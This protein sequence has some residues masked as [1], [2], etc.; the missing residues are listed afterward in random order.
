M[1]PVKLLDAAFLHAETAQT[2]MHVGA[3]FVLEKP[4]RRPRK[5]F[6][7]RFR[8]LVAT[9]L[10]A[11][12]V[13]TR[14]LAALPFDIA[15]PFWAITDDIDLDHHVRHWT[16][17]APG[18][19]RQLETRVARLH[20]PLMDRDRPLWELH[21]IDGLEDGRIALYVKTHHAGLDGHT[22][23]LFL[24]AFVDPGPR[25]SSRARPKPLPA[26]DAASLAALLMAGA[27]HQLAELGRVP[28]RIRELADAAATLRRG[29]DA[30]VPE[31][32]RTILNEV[33]SRR[34]SF[35][36]AEVDLEQVRALAR[37]AQVKVNDV[38]L[39]M[40]AAAV[41]GWLLQRGLLPQ[42]PL[43]AGV[44]VSARAAGD[45]DHSIQVAF[46][47]VNLHTGAGD[48]L[49]RLMAIHRSASAAKDTA[50]SFKALIP[51]DVPSVGL[52][53]LLGGVA[54]LVSHPDVADRVPLPFNVI[55]SNVPGPPTTLYVAGARVGTY[56]P[57]SIVYHGVGLNVTAYSYDGKLF[58][59]VTACTDLMPD[60]QSFA[61][62]MTGE[63]AVLSAA[64]ERPRARSGPRARRKARG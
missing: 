48:P 42:L 63:L 4:S 24:Q 13:F 54:R 6:H 62:L 14:R 27:R 52:P 3:L 21:V 47:S 49:A 1:K 38:L 7:Q 29:R 9:R 53:W 32:P 36:T 40:T 18:S 8:E 35:A 30:S 16:L 64:L 28:R 15:N 11:S 41:R 60:V 39:A 57:V 51:D 34:R 58:I 37:R 59:G 43:F 33:V 50:G 20:E 10:G 45:T 17:P 55:V 46:I 26:P 44:P 22:A 56:L 19:W 12:E 5:P 25:P 23:Q 31:T 2:P 61:R